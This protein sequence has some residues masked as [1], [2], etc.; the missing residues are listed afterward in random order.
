MI[1]FWAFAGMSRPHLQD[2]LLGDLDPTKTRDSPPKAF[3][4]SC[5]DSA[6]I[7]SMSSL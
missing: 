5:P 1:S 4:A 3:A 6:K 7:Q 2:D